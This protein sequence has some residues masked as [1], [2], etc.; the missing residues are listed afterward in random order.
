[1]RIFVGLLALSLMVAAPGPARAG[2]AEDATQAVTAWLDRF[3]AGDMNAFF[4]G[5]Q[6][7]A[8]IID[9]FAPFTWSGSGSA[10][11]WAGD[12]ARDAAARG[13]SEGRVDYSAPIQANSDGTTAYVVL[14]T[15]YRFLQGGRRMAGRGSMTF[16]M[17]HV[18]TSWKV[19]SWT[20]AGATPTPE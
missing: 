1:M 10:Q 8:L 4:A 12:Y 20:Y 15:I 16:V 11:R 19:A 14:P 18:G 3:N 5:H 17:T 13:I 7:N 6:D 2:P 9:E